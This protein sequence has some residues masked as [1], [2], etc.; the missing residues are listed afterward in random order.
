MKHRSRII[1]VDESFY[2]LIKEVSLRED[3]SVIRKTKELAK[4][5]KKEELRSGGFD[6]RI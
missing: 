3:V 1:R 4:K 5:L 2:K 6:F